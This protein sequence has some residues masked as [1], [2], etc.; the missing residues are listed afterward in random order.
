MPHP[1]KFQ[2]VEGLNN[3]SADR[4]SWGDGGLKIISLCV[5]VCVCVCACMRAGGRGYGFFLELYIV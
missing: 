5:C 1:R 3:L 2:G 4:K